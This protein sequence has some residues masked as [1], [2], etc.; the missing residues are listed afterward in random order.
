MAN[1]EFLLQGSTVMVACD[2]DEKIR[3]IFQ[4][5]R[6]K[7]GLNKNKRIFYLYSGRALN[8]DSDLTFEQTATLQD[9]QRNKMTIVVVVVLEDE[10]LQEKSK[11]KPEEKKENDIIKQKPII[12]PECKEN[13]KLEIRDFKINL[14]GCENG[15]KRENILLNEFEETQKVDESKIICDICRTNNKRDTYMNAFFRCYTCRKNMC[16]LC[17]YKH[18]KSHEIINY[19]LFKN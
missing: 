11:E 2:I 4:K 16:P 13:I 3:D 10:E 7:V 6:N 12:C 5:F 19:E 17:E 18:D 9:K 8:E 1:I 15:H 14:F